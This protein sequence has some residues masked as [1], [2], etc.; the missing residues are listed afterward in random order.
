MPLIVIKLECS[1]SE[2]AIV[3]GYIT[4][5]INVN[6]SHDKRQA[7]R[8]GSKHIALHVIHSMMERHFIDP[9]TIDVIRLEE[10]DEQV[11]LPPDAGPAATDVS[12]PEDRST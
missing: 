10:I 9:N 4:A 1:D 3:E 5:T 7:W 12:R 8:F 6:L 2:G 11:P